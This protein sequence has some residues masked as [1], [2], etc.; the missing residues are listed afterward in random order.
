MGD[1][2]SLRK[3]AEKRADLFFR[4]AFDRKRNV[5]AP[6]KRLRTC[7]IRTPERKVSSYEAGMQDMFLHFC[8]PL[9]SHRRL[10]HRLHRK[11]SAQAFFIECHCFAAITIEDEICIDL[12][13]MNSCCDAGYKRT[14]INR[15]HLGVYAPIQGVDY[16]IVII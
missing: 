15:I 14:A 5:I 12:G 2:A 4:A 3:V 11:L 7:H 9:I 6:D 13:H 10:F 8:R 1:P 16:D